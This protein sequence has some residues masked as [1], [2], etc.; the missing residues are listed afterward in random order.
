MWCHIPGA[1]KPLATTSWCRTCCKQVQEGSWALPEQ[2]EQCCRGAGQS[3]VLLGSHQIPTFPV[4]LCSP[5]WTM[6]THHLLWVPTAAPQQQTSKTSLPW[7]LKS[8]IPFHHTY[9]SCKDLCDHRE[10]RLC[11]PQGMVMFLLL[12][13]LLHIPPSSVW[14]GHGSQLLTAFYWIPLLSELQ[15]TITRVKI[16]CQYHNLLFTIQCMGFADMIQQ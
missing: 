2:P 7:T 3:P 15:E 6:Y 14:K 1:V 5:L 13:L 8:Q 16:K 4:P 10:W 11:Y 12:M 9:H